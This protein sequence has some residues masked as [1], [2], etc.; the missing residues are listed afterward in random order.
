MKEH[1]LMW[2]TVTLISSMALTLGSGCSQLKGPQKPDPKTAITDPAGI[3]SQAVV[4]AYLEY[5]GP[6]ERWAGPK[7][8]VIHVDATHVSGIQVKITSAFEDSEMRG[9]AAK[10][11]GSLRIPTTAEAR[12]QLTELAVVSSSQ[13][14]PAFQACVNPIRV[15]LIRA[16]QSVVEKLG[17]R[18]Q[19]EWAAKVSNLTSHFV[20]AS[21]ALALMQAPPRNEVAS[22]RKGGLI[23]QI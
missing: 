5:I 17:C 1:K 22:V 7:P 18:G 4:E 2:K 13:V 6:P 21:L 12:N 15:R 14:V 23:D 11:G 8:F 19:G 16:D 3:N 20:E 10:S 9:W